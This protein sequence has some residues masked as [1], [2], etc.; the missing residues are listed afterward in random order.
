MRFLVPARRETVTCEEPAEAE[1]FRAILDVF[2]SKEFLP[3]VAIIEEQIL[4]RMVVFDQL[5]LESLSVWFLLVV[6]VSLPGGL[7][8]GF[9]VG[10]R[11]V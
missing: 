2:A 5:L 6:F 3:I 7:F 10:V 11:R 8:E 1:S 9:V 4:V